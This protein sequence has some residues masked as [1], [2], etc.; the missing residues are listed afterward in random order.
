M[1][2]AALLGGGTVCSVPGAVSAVGVSLFVTGTDVAL[3]H[4]DGLDVTDGQ[5][6]APAPSGPAGLA[7]LKLYCSTDRVRGLSYQGDADPPKAAQAAA[8]LSTLPQND[9]PD[10]V[11]GRGLPQTTG[12]KGRALKRTAAN[13]FSRHFSLRLGFSEAFAH[14][15]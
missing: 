11:T 14:L 6:S 7:R 12:K 4:R 1:V 3:R 5:P 8:H 2:R 9:K 15:K 13:N 10:S